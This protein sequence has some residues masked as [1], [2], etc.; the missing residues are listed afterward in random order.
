MPCSHAATR[1]HH[2][3]LENPD[4]LPIS[5][6]KQ[7]LPLVVRSGTHRGGRRGAMLPALV[8]DEEGNNGRGRGGRHCGRPPG[9]RPTGRPRGRPRRQ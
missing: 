9:V 1:R 3:S 4:F 2:L 7:L 6:S 8:R 5:P